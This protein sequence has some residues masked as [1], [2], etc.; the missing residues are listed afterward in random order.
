M[1]GHRTNRSQQKAISKELDEERD[2]NKDDIA[3]LEMLE[4]HYDERQKA[5]EV[6]WLRKSLIPCTERFI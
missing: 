1:I 6:S 2:R 5:Y 4:K 3:Y